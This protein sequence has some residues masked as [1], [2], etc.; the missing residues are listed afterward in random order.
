MQWYIY[1]SFAFTLKLEHDQWKLFY[2]QD[3]NINKLRDD[4]KYF[5]ITRAT[6]TTT[7]QVHGVWRPAT[8]RKADILWVRPPL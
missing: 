6:P 4:L 3:I 5:G 7:E 8:T 1:Q 2:E